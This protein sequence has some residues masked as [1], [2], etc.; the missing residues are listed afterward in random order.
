M[1]ADIPD[2]AVAAVA[3][4]VLAAT[5]E[6]RST[7]SRWNL[8]A[9]TIRAIRDRGWQFSTP[10][11]LI[12]AR[13][14]VLAQAI[15]QSVSLD[16]PELAEVPAQWRDPSTGRSAF[17]GP[18]TF[19]SRAV[20]DA[21]GRLLAAAR[22]RSAPTAPALSGD[23]PG[24]PEQVAAVQAICGSGRTLDVLVGAAGTGKTAT[25][26]RLA[27]RWRAEHGDHSVLLLA[28][29]AAATDIL[30][31][32]TG[33]P[34]ETA[35]MWLTRHDHRDHD[36]ARHAE[37]QR[38]RA[39]ELWINQFTP[40]LDEESDR[41][42]RRLSQIQIRPGSLLVLDEAGMADVHPL[43]RLTVAATAA[44]AKIL[45]VGDDHQL[46]PV[47]PGGSFG[48]LVAHRPDI[49]HLSNIQRFRDPDGTTRTWE[50]HASAHLRVGDPT[51]LQAYN[52]HNRIRGGERTAMLDAAYRAWRTDTDNGLD[53]L[54]L[55]ADN[56]TVTHLNR[57]AQADRVAD[58]RVH[59][60]GVPLADGTTAGIGDR[61]ITRRNDS[62]LHPGDLTKPAAAAGHRD[63]PVGFVRNGQQLTVTATHADG[64]LTAA[65]RTGRT[66]AL[67]AAY[68]AEHVQLGYAATIHR[69]QGATVD[70]S[71]VIASPGT[72]RQALYVALTR[73]RASNVA[74]TITETPD[75]SGTLDRLGPA[76]PVDTP[77]HAFARILV[78][79]GADHSAHTTLRRTFDQAGS[80]RQLL[81]EYAQIAE[82]A[83]HQRV[84]ALIDTLGPAFAPAAPTPE[85]PGLGDLQTHRLTR[86]IRAG[87]R[88]GLNPERLLPQI[89]AHTTDLDQLTDH[90]ERATQHAKRDHG[91][92]SAVRTLRDGQPTSTVGITD[93]DIRRALLQREELINRTPETLTA[94]RHRASTT[95]DGIDH[96]LAVTRKPH[97]HQQIDRPDHGGTTDEPQHTQPRTG[98]PTARRLVSLADAAAYAA[99]CPETIRRRI[100]DG[101]LHGCRLGKRL[102][103]VDLNEIDAALRPN[104]TADAWPRAL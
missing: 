33:T 39:A 5:E 34:A 9:E 65:D 74:Y 10:R 19:T 72:T 86:A 58:G 4:Q 92:H 75:R 99:C 40:A 102:V 6:R 24:N 52:D 78:R 43:D 60:G 54:L 12:S 28:V 69:A 36:L 66:V 64:S 30:A 53:S 16:P 44:G 57:R 3:D 77:I 13:D 97:G 88:Y 7:W 90:Y 14:R 63:P 15:G 71:H 79:D 23:H 51:A 18:E 76:C 104:P 49:P 80:R 82:H 22:D 95:D 38:L 91:A 8:T 48:M 68:V 100:S 50:A 61:I 45:L 85:A 93:P 101:T 20:L 83:H 103:R 81:L 11:D 1:A 70:T 32:A 62:T 21:E 46:S 87:D 67:P 89:A 47:G 29:S 26:N 73:G 56:D 35:A 27:A 42:T 25:I 41:L 94:Q 17:A 84:T 98:Q 31:T 59:T 37:V 2:A 55:A 96:S